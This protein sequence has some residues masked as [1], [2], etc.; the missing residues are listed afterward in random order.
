MRAARA[1]VENLPK[2]VNVTE[3]P[4]FRACGDRFEHGVY[5]SARIALGHTRAIG[6]GVDEILLCHFSPPDVGF[7]LIEPKDP[8]TPSYLAQ[9]CRLPAVFATR[10]GR[11]RGR[12]L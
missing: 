3:S 2:P 7:E 5:R 12:A 9:P 10:A 11:S 6:D 1:D 8:N 4:L